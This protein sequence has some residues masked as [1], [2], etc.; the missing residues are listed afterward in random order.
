MKK[1]LLLI[2]LCTGSLGFAQGLSERDIKF[3]KAAA[4]G[5]MMEVQLG[6]TSQRNAYTQEV[7]TCGRRM[8]E[9]HSKGNDELKE[10]AAKKKITLPAAID[11]KKKKKCDELYK[12]TGKTFDKA[13]AKLMIKDHKA[14][15]EEFKTEAKK[16]SDPDL[17]AWAADKVP[18][19]QSHLEMWEAAYK[20]AKQ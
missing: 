9:D 7:K 18:T 19:L 11:E 3:A 17:K 6:E 15:I 4:E 1:N 20:A 12:L 5:G 2:L 16:G 10:L 8:V 14:D 13:Y